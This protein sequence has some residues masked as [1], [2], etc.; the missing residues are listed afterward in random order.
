MPC[1]IWRETANFL[2]FHVF[3]THLPLSAD[4]L[5]TLSAATLSVVRET[6]KDEPGWKFSVPGAA[7]PEL[8]R[9][10][11]YVPGDEHNKLLSHDDS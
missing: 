3:M 7:M 6:R 11:L 2:T 1:L 9:R 10:V 8:V 4:C 5:E